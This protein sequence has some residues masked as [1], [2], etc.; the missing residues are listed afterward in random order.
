MRDRPLSS[1]F[2]TG[3]T[4][5][6]LCARPSDRA[7]PTRVRARRSASPRFALAP[8]A[9]AAATVL[10]P[11]SAAA[12]PARRHAPSTD[13]LPSSVPAATARTRSADPPAI[14][15]RRV[16]LGACAPSPDARS[17]SS[18][19]RPVTWRGR[20]APMPLHF[21]RTTAATSRA[22]GRAS[23]HFTAYECAVAAFCKTQCRVVP[24][25]RTPHRLGPDRLQSCHMP[26]STA[27]PLW[28]SHPTHW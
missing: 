28:S 9:V 24:A 2:T 1:C 16:R 5:V 7:P 15:N 14:Q 22:F 17:G 6:G 3:V 10:P 8:S 12:H 20:S 25:L 18:A 19:I 21:A 27:E 13:A 23:A 4:S 26:R 11:P